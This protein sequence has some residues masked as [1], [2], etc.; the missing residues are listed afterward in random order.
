MDGDV[1]F[2]K[3]FNGIEFFAVP[4]LDGDR[5]VY[6]TARSLTQYLKKGSES[7][8]AREDRVVDKTGRRILE[9]IASELEKR[10]YRLEINK[11]NNQ[12]VSPLSEGDID[13]TAELPTNTSVEVAE[14]HL[15]KAY[16]D[17][18]KQWKQE[19]KQRLSP[20]MIVTQTLLG[21]AGEIMTPE[22][23][24]KW[25]AEIAAAVRGNETGR[26]K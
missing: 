18:I 16:T 19:K 21:H 23:A 4:M 1:Y 6:I 22:K 3:K 25:A 14:R 24:P 12:Y 5:G 10:G 7:I 17:A 2:R 11:E 9:I 20:E 13:L 15:D 8:S 26:N